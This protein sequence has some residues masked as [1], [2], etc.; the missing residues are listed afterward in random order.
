M[1]YP[2]PELLHY[3]KQTRIGV[4][5]NTFYVIVVFYQK[6]VLPVL[7]I[8]ANC[9]LRAFICLFYL[10]IAIHFYYLLLKRRQGRRHSRIAE[11]VDAKRA[12]DIAATPICV[13]IK[14]KNRK[15]LFCG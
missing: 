6:D 15:I 2:E 9:K 4:K 8:L 12:A 10:K 13:S 14:N 7:L 11:I 1:V 3:V 5:N